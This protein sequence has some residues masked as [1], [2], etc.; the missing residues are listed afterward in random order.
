MQPY[1]YQGHFR[2]SIGLNTTIFNDRF[3]TLD[4]KQCYNFTPFSHTIFIV[5]IN[6]STYPVFVDL[7]THV[8]KHLGDENGDDQEEKKCQ[9]DV[10][11]GQGDLRRSESRPAIIPESYIKRTRLIHRLGSDRTSPKML[12][13]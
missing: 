2:T 4:I 9:V 10:P 6:F 5:F 3:M 11:A 13:V 8:G 12:F 7:V 1:V